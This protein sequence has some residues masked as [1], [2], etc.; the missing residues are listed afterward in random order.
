[1]RDPIAKIL[2]LDYNA[3]KED[4]I[5]FLDKITKD[6]SPENMVKVKVARLL[7]QLDLHLLNHSLKHISLEIRLNPS[8]V[9]NDIKMLQ[10]CSGKGEQ[11]ALESI[12]YTSNYEFSNGCRAPPWRQ[13]HGDICYVLVKPH[14]V[15]PLCVTCSSEGVFLN[16]GK[17]D[18]DG[19]IDY[20]RKGEIYK[21]LV[22]FL[23]DKSV[24]F[25]ENMSKQENKLSDKEQKENDQPTEA[26]KTE[27]LPGF[28]K[29]PGLLKSAP[30]KNQINLVKSHMNKRLEPSL[31][32]IATVNLKDKSAEKIEE[33]ISE[34]SSESEEDEEPPDHR[35][36]A[37]AD[38]PSEY[39]QIQK[40]VKYL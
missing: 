22:T 39:W 33:I 36:E 31:K 9:K 38:L 14:D 4:S 7:K 27:E 11:T 13:I 1:N 3:V 30:E 34:S 12:E 28:H 21:D 5:N 6:D 32:W 26:P 19:E 15:E 35:Q 37:N 8:T 16:G 10:S 40:L 25:S 29:S 20:E 2:G 18:D 24:K 23:K 17:T